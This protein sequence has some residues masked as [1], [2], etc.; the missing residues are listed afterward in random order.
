LATFRSQVVVLSDD[1]GGDVEALTDKWMCWNVITIS[2][3]QAK[4]SDCA[5]ST[6][7]T[8]DSTAVSEA[9]HR[10]SSHENYY[11]GETPATISNRWPAHRIRNCSSV[12]SVWLPTVIIPNRCWTSTVSSIAVARTRPT[13]T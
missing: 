3:R 2:D 7:L 8:A 5:E 1:L 10:S 13:M 9:L 4:N 12:N 11:S 6:S